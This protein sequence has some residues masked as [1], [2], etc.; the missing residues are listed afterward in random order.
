[1]FKA[2]KILLNAAALLLVSAWVSHASDAKT[3]L[4]PAALQ[5]LSGGVLLGFDA[6]P[7]PA[8]ITIPMAAPERV[9][10]ETRAGAPKPGGS[11]VVTPVCPHTLANR[12]IVLSGNETIDI[13]HLLFSFVWRS[14]SRRWASAPIDIANGGTGPQCPFTNAP[15]H[16]FMRSAS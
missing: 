12:T 6:I 9:A 1:M 7:A 11:I 16:T 4:Q 2:R 10:E 14:L 15:S 8:E 3:D 5:S 13:G